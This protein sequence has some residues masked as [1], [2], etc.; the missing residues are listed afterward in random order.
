MKESLK[1]GMKNAPNLTGKFFN[2]S[3]FNYV[4]SPPLMDMTLPVM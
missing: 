2:S 4:Y 1:R 3:F